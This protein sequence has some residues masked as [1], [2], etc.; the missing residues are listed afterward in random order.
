[1]MRWFREFCEVP[2]EKFKARLHIHS[3]QDEQ[4]MKSFWSETTGIPLAQFGKS[5]VKKEG[6]GH[7]KNILYHGTIQVVICNK[8]LLHKIYGW[9]DGFVERLPFAGLCSSI[10]RAAPS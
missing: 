3:G 5:Y 1:M 10:G 7:R 8:N 9:I 4:S 2:Q 6:S